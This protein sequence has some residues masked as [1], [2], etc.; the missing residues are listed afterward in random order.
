MPPCVENIFANSS[1]LEVSQN[2]NG[3]RAT[4]CK[5][6][7]DEKIFCNLKSSIQ[8]LIDWFLY[9]SIW[10]LIARYPFLIAS[11]NDLSTLSRTLSVVLVLCSS[12]F[13]DNAPP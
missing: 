2:S 6:N 13:T 8:I 5:V 7:S 10:L 12:R 4:N 1:P 3:A 11:F 9:V